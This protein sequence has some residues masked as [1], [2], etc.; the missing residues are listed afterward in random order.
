MTAVSHQAERQR[1]RAQGAAESATRGQDESASC[2]P[3]GIYAKRFLAAPQGFC[4]HR[5]ALIP[6]LRAPP[7]RG[8]D[9]IE[10]GLIPRICDSGH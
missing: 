4:A 1:S 6:S 10:G 8:R 2:V 7:P 5:F 3:I 9:D